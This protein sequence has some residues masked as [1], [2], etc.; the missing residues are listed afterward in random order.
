MMF[1]PA[2]GNTDVPFP[3]RASHLLRKLEEA[4]EK[5]LTLILFAAIGTLQVLG[6][7]QA[8]P[9]VVG[10]RLVP[11]PWQPRTYQELRKL[12]QDMGR[13]MLQAIS[14]LRPHL[15]SQAFRIV[16]E[17]L[18]VMVLHHGLFDELPS[19]FASSATEEELRQFLR[20][21]FNHMIGMRE[22]QQKTRPS[23]KDPLLELLRQWDAELAPKDLSARIKDLTA[24]D[25]WSVMQRVETTTNG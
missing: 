23:H 2:L 17:E 10:G 21:K 8:P 13:R 5:T 7:R 24:Q 15:R 3:D 18:P 14:H 25:Y 12:Q 16:I 6:G 20:V 19:S 1:W 9:T 11:T 22:F 4:D